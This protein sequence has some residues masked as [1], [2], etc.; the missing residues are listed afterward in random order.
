MKY[1]VIGNADSLRGTKLGSYIDS[2]DVVVRLNYGYLPETHDDDR[3]HKTT[4][5]YHC[6]TIRKR[7][8]PPPG[9]RTK[10]VNHWLRCQLQKTFGEQP[11]SGVMAAIDYANLLKP[12]DTLF[13]GGISFFEA[14]YI[15]KYKL[16]KE[17]L[18][19]TRLKMLNNQS[20]VHSNKSDKAAFQF[21]VLNKPGVFFDPY[22][23]NLLS[24]PPDHPNAFCH[25]KTGH[26]PSHL[27]DDLS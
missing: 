22:P 23:T 7:M 5:I 4:V 15:E 10:L 18:E 11:T 8:S 1:A 16:S 6:S 26:A 3:G 21:C 19:S 2:C 17:L 25:V 20:T 9:V 27:S 13:I 24:L 14:S 12:G